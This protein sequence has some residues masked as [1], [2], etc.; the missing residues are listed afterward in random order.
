[1]VRPRWEYKVWSPGEFPWGPGGW[2]S[3]GFPKGSGG[4]PKAPGGFPSFRNLVR[5]FE[6]Y[7]EQFTEQFTELEAKLEAKLNELGADGW[8]LMERSDG[9]WFIFKREGCRVAD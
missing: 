2:G 4:F 3:G 6:E 7:T 8:E 5:D 1:M 9:F